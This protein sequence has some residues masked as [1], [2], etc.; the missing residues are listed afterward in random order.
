LVTVVIAHTASERTVGKEKGR[1]LA[2]AKVDV[3]LSTPRVKKSKENENRM[4]QFLKWLSWVVVKMLELCWV[5][6][7]HYTSHIHD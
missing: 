7:F 2:R 5:L 6:V 3:A 4:P 1:I